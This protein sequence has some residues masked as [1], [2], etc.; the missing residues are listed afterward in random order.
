MTQH[1]L[2][3]IL[4]SFNRVRVVRIEEGYIHA[5]FVSAVFGFVDDVGFY[6][7]DEKKIIHIKSASRS[8]YFDFGVNRR[9][10]EK[11]RKLFE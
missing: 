8:G 1:K 7:D 9:R 6:F 10:M 2:L 3:E 5:E 4:H 11:I